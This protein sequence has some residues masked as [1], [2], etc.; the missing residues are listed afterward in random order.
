[1]K[2]QLPRG[3]LGREINEEL[4]IRSIVKN[5]RD[6]APAKLLAIVEANLCHLTCRQQV[7]V[8]E[9]MHGRPVVE[10]AAEYSTSKT[11]VYKVFHAGVAALRRLL[12]N[13]P[14]VCDLLK[15]M[16]WT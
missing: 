16:R 3:A 7:V 1:M 12:V 2:A 10:L 14:I 4:L 8:G 11:A 15:E 5:A 6:A 13:D 9:I